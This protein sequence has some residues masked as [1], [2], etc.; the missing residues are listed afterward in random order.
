MKVEITV[1]HYSKQLVV[2]QELEYLGIYCIFAFTWGHNYLLIFC[3]ENWTI[4]YYAYRVGSLTWLY[5]VTIIF[6]QKKEKGHWFCLKSNK[7]AINKYCPFSYPFLLFPI[8]TISYKNRD[9]IKQSHV[10]NS[11]NIQYQPFLSLVY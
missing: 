1:V 3:L 10:R 11:V 2:F 4:Q 7:R 8:S 5:T 6:R 9:Y